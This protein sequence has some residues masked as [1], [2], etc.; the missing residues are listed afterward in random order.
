MTLFR[1][2]DL[3]ASSDVSPTAARSRQRSWR[4]PRIVV[5][6]ALVALSVLVG[7]RVLARAD[8]TVA[9]LAAR[10]PLSSGQTVRADDLTTVRLR[11]ASGRDADR[12]LPADAVPPE[13]SVLLRAVGAGELVPRDAV[14]TSDAPAV[15]QV[16]VALEPGRVPAGLRPGSVVDVW[17]TPGESEVGSG[18]GDGE[19]RLLLEAVPVL[20]TA[21][22][23][24]GSG[25]LRQ[26]VVGVPPEAEGDLPAVLAA[27]GTG[28]PVLVVR[29][30]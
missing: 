21:R 29:E 15:V 8:E 4:D 14:S 13:G 18:D 3:G 2:S 19:A 30:R 26:V 23:G 25:G 27:L 28:D 11:F 17:V 6:V 20:A 16:P 24:G 9:V 1:T 12:Y 7:A 10:V 22:P 5:G